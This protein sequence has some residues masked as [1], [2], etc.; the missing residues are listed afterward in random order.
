MSL[1]TLL[2]PYEIRC[3][4]VGGILVKPTP[5][6]WKAIPTE[7]LHLVPNVYQNDNFSRK[8]LE[9]ESSKGAHKKELSN[10]QKSL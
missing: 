2:Q 4:N 5:K 3:R 8:V 1:N 7:T 6:K 10:L 9:N